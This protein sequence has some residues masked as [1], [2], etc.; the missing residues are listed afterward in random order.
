MNL[1]QLVKE[2]SSADGLLRS[3]IKSDLAVLTM[4]SVRTIESWYLRPE[5]I[6]AQDIEKINNYFG[7]EAEVEE[8]TQTEA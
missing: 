7:I 8:L 2:K 3:R 1:K 5:I 4:K 6:S